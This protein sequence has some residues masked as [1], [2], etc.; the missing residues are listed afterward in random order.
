MENDLEKLQRKNN[1]LLKEIQSLKSPSQVCSNC[2]SLQNK[3]N[4]LNKTL[5]KF[6][7]GKKNLE[8]LI[9]NQ[10]HAFNK[11]GLGYIPST[12]KR[13][14]KN[15]FVRK[16]IGNQPHMTVDKGT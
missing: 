2:E 10:R 5:E 4:D 12:S 7:S 14:Y 3:I 16:T 9:G 1:D 13:F 15:L 6:T 8:T 11:E